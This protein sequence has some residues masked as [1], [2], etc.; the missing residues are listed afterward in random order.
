M[1]KFLPSLHQ[2]KYTSNVH[3]IT[4][5]NAVK[6]EWDTMYMSSIS[7]ERKYLLDSYP[8][9]SNS[10]NTFIRKRL[11]ILGKLVQSH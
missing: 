7:S 11:L 1:S 3:F 10:V 6:F 9:I 8:V 2:L 4:L 5:L